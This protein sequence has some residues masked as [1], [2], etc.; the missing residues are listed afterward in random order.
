MATGVDIMSVKKLMIGVGNRDKPVADGTGL[1]W[2][3]DIHAIK[4]MTFDPS[5]IPPGMMPGQ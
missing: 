2:L 4:T 1:I 3:D 5:Q